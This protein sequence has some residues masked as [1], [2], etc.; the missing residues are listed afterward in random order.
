MV[1]QVRIRASHIRGE[2]GRC[3]LCVLCVCVCA[4]A[5]ERERERNVPVDIGPSHFVRHSDGTC[6]FIKL[7]EL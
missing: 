5:R 1:C 7:A 6:A 3:A 2:P 4:R